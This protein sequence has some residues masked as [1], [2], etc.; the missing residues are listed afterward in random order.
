MVMDSEFKTIPWDTYREYP[1]AEMLQK[2]EDFR[3]L[4]ARRRSVRGFSDRAVSLEVINNCLET[5]GSSVSGANMQ[6]WSFVVVSDQATKHEIR[7]AAEAEEKAFYEGRAPQAWLD[8][9]KPLGTDPDKGFLEVAPYL[10]GIFQQRFGELPD[11]RKVKHY[12]PTESVGIA[13]GML[14]TALHNAGL[15]CLTHTPS[16]MKFLNRI[17]K[18]PTN[19]RPFL[20]L[21]VG[22]PAVGVRVPDITKKAPEE[23]ISYI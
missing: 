17:M 3:D 13:T 2:S 12:Y 20:L 21:V 11:G 22:Y 23:F 1:G 6:P 10:I 15:A 5:A 4:M 9:L 16:P 18:R 8:A 19:E 14:I 7:V